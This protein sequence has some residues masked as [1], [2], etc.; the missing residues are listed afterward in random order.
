M[1]KYYSHDIFDKSITKGSVTI[2]ISLMDTD[3][4]H[5]FKSGALL[6]STT[7]LLFLNESFHGCKKKKMS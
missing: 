2:T 7:S 5:P 4:G 1:V 3:D 6:F